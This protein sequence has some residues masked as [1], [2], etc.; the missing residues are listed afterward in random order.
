M[1]PKHALSWLVVATLGGGVVLGARRTAVSAAA[2]ATAPHQMRPNAVPVVVELFTSEGCSSCPPADALLARLEQT[3]PVAGAE[4][5]LLAFHVDYWDG[6]G[7]PDPFSSAS[8][9]A[10]QRGYSW[11]G[12]G[13]YTPEAVVDG[14]TD[15]VG[16]HAALLERAITNAAALPH[17]T[18][19]V[20]VRPRDRT[21]D[22]TVRVGPSSDGSAGAEVFVALVRNEAQVSVPRGENAG[23]RLHHTAIVRE[24]V[25]AGR[26]PTRGGEVH[27]S[28]QQL[29]DVD[30]AK[31]LHV[32]GFAQRSDRRQIVGA[33]I[34][35]VTA[36]DHR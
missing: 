34:A 18:L 28:L 17:R 12:A 16:S 6:L 7:W 35:E 14:R 2:P 27:A 30:D 8:F 11:L 5:V 10:R 13:M 3:Q 31:S 15:V 25:S 19:Q 32:V 4:I 20:A 26:V 33:A 36:S 9:T 23:K 21:F 24:L 1:K 29:R 22:V